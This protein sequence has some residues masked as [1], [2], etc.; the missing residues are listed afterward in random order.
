MELF[1]RTCVVH[2]PPDKLCGLIKRDRYFVARKKTSWGYNGKDPFK[3]P[4]G[5]AVTESMTNYLQRN[6]NSN[7]TESV[8]D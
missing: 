6:Y 2:Y 3:H 7:Q 1:P 5:V 4:Q 8:L